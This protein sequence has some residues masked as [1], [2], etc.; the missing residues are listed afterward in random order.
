MLNILSKNIYTMLNVIEKL[1]NEETF[2]IILYV[3][4]QNKL[5]YFNNAYY[6]SMLLYNLMLNKFPIIILQIFL[7]NW[8]SKQ[9]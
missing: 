5:I 3:I 4:Y 6:R 8:L 9:Y 1:L 2:S 7:I